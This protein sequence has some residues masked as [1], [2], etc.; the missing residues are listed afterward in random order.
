MT[1]KNAIHFSSGGSTPEPTTG[2]FAWGGDVS[3]WGGNYNALAQMAS[4]TDWDS[5][6]LGSVHGLAIKNG[7]LYSWGYNSSG[8]TG[9]GTTSQTYTI[10]PTQVGSETD[11]WKISA[12][13]DHSLGIRKTWNTDH[14]DYTLWVWGEGGYYATGTG[15]TTDLSTP[16]QIG[17]DTDWEHISAGTQF[18]CA[19]R[20]GVLYTCG[21]NSQ[22]RTG[23]NVSTG[24]TT[25]WT[26]YDSSTG[27]TWCGGGY[28]YGLGVKSGEL[29]GWGEGGQRVFGDGGTTD[30][31]I[32]TQIGSYTDW[33]HGTCGYS[34]SLMIKTDGT[35]WVTGTGLSYKLGNSSTSAVSTFTQIGSDTDW[36]VVK[37]NG[38]S[39]GADFVYFSVAIKGNK[40]YVAGINSL[41]QC[42]FDPGTYSEVQ[43]W[44]QVGT[45]T[46]YV[47]IGAGSGFGMACRQ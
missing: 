42:G 9:L 35:L 31:P 3:S 25:T 34:H 6:A 17:S 26:S 39:A 2:L 37:V 44:T 33:S 21:N 27:W 8:R 32:P 5:V 28:N 14:Y 16:T 4:G 1:I 22:Y 24:Q 12:G 29:F 19:I 46:N 38:N 11:W 40:L 20:A 47:D 10:K 43:T 30:K 18:S 23:Q 13:S 36:Q 15:S 41:A 7:A 45:G